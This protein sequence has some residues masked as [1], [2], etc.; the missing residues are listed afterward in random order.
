MQERWDHRA[1]LAE[2]AI[3]ERH[4]HRVWGLPRTN[5]CVVSWP[6][7]TR[8]S[9]FVRWHYWWQAHYLDC[10]IDAA[11]RVPTRD[12]ARRINYTLRG[13]RVRNILSLTHNR[14]YDDKAW[15]TLAMGRAQQLN[16]VNEP[17][18]LT[19]LYDNLKTGVDD[20]VGVLPWRTG[21]NFFNVP[22]NGPTAIAFARGDDS[23]HAA[24]MVDWIFDNLVAPNGLIQDGWR[25]TMN[26]PETVKRTYTYCQGVTLGACVDIIRAQQAQGTQQSSKSQGSPKTENV[27]ELESDD[28][29]QQLRFH[30]RIHHL[31]DAISN[32]MAD[33]DGVIGGLI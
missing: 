31:V 28:T 12:R 30:T 8:D 32:S 3:N 11:N 17:K 23:D 10:L 19:A 29:T 6:A 1:D 13:M 16:R 15:L 14:Y 25:L 5:L 18:A 9:V 24:D 27:S 4:A 22:T 21:E 26:G 20:L 7:R 2:T 33:A